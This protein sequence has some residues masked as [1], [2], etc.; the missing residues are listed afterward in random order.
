LKSLEEHK[1]HYFLRNTIGISGVELFWGLGLPI[2]FESTFLQ[3]FLTGLGA[4]S[5]IIGL[6]PA[7]ASTGVAL[8]SIMSALL[9][10]HLVHKKKVLIITHVIAGSPLIFFGFILFFTGNSFISVIL[11]LILYSLFSL[12]VG[13]TLPL[14]QNYI[15]AIFNENEQ[16]PAISVMMLCQTFAKLI[17]SFIIFKLVEKFAFSTISS[18]FLFICIGLIFIFGSFLFLLT[19]ELHHE[20]FSNSES[21]FNLGLFLKD[22]KSVLKNKNLLFFIFSTLESCICISI[23]SFYANYATKFYSIG[24]S[25]AAGIFVG[26]IYIGGIIANISFGW[27]NLFKMK[28]KIIFSKIIAFSA[29]LLLVFFPSL[30]IFFIISFLLGISRGTSQLIFSPAIK[31]LSGKHDATV[32]FAIASIFML[33]L[34]FGIPFLSGVY[35]E[36]FGFL[37]VLS[38]KILFTAFLILLSVSLILATMTRFE[39]SKK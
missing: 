37:K 15:V 19:K 21:L 23:I 26:F 30:I 24:A 18:A 11:F 14:W 32:H 16:M 29:C 12:G 1:K 10:A 3:L 27:F 13:L 4:G 35:L 20:S 25:Y 6:I 33:P 39:D 36:Q 31:K 7:I 2:I 22:A 28:T 8:F 38:Y 5:R 17:S 9:T 34:N